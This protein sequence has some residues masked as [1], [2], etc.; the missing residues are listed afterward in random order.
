MDISVL[1][2]EKRVRILICLEK[3]QSVSQL[4]EK[5][6]LSQSALSQHLAKLKKAGFV[7]CSREGNYQ[8]YKTKNKK[9]TKVAK[10]II[11]LI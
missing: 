8:I 6:E 7:N 10:S 11:D 9:I 5:C 4:L 2:N 3:P 1:S